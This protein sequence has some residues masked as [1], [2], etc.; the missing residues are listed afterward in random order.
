MPFF[1]LRIRWAESSDFGPKSDD[2]GHR[3]LESDFIPSDFAKSDCISRPILFSH[4]KIK[5][6]SSESDRI[7]NGLRVECPRRFWE[8][9]PEILHTCSMCPCRAFYQWDLFSFFFASYLGFCIFWDIWVLRDPVFPAKKKKNKNKKKS[10]KAR[11]G[12][13]K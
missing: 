10:S 13:I 6:R 1:D 8:I 5:M 11:Q 9:D 12:H 4:R 3:I 7:I 2:L